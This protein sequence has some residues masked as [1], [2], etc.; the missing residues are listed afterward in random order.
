MTEQVNIRRV[1]DELLRTE[2][3]AFIGMAFRELYPGTP[4]LDNWHIILLAHWLEAMITGDCKRLVVCMPPRHLK[5][6][7]ASICLPALLLGRDPTAKIV[8]VSYGQNLADDLAHQTLKIMTSAWYKR[9]FPKTRLDPGRM[10]KSQFGTTRNGH[11]IASS[12]GGTITGKGGDFLIL[13]DL[14]KADDVHSDTVRESTNNWF[15]TSLLSRLNQPHT[16]RILVVAQR[17]HV[18]DVP[19]RLLERGGW[20]S[21]ILPLIA[22]E[23][24][25]F[26]LGSR[27]I[28]RPPGVLLH[29][30]RMNQAYADQL[31]SD[32]GHTL[33]EAQY[34]QRPTPAGGYLFEMDWLKY[35]ESPIDPRLCDYVLQSWD[36]A[37]MTDEKNDYTVCATFGVIGSDYHLLDIYRQKVTF[38][39]QVQL[40]PAMRVKW[41]ADL[42]IVEGAGSGL[43]LH[44]TIRNEDQRAF[45]LTYKVPK[46]AKV[47][48]AEKQTVKFS[49]G[50]VRLP[51]QAAW[52]TAF[53][54]ELAAF[55]KGRH[56]D[57]V[58]AVVQFLTAV[59]GNLGGPIEVARRCGR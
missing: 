25:N 2:M 27:T 59:D 50:R 15:D 55:P 47:E 56:D 1:L 22:Y 8:C 17:L 29:P 13:D 43:M 19:G 52:R 28:N 46:G 36:T 40:I 3:H 42:V 16:G 49:Q 20:D 37:Y 10:K 39:E 11:R 21:I 26:D 9:I 32:I 23:E 54:S 4:Y 14:I 34:N 44:Q 7:L 35:D 45:W 33:F 41:G 51:R 24:E 53:E 12:V 18:D 57:Q 6:F 58:D 5:S 48:R 30:E 31:R 38:P